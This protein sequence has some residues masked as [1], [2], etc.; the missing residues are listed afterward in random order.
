MA[1]I[2]VGIFL[3]IYRF[4]AAILNVRYN[5]CTSRKNGPYC[6]WTTILALCDGRTTQI[7]ILS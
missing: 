7:S 5:S 6:T 3:S 1:K 4:L 2:G